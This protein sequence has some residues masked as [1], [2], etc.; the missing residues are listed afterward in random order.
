MR[1]L[2]E[3]PRAFEF[4]IQLSTGTLALNEVQARA[5]VQG[6]REHGIVFYCKDCGAL[7]HPSFVMN[8]DRRKLPNGAP[9]PGTC[10]ECASPG[11]YLLIHTVGHALMVWSRMVKEIREAND[12]I[13]RENRLEAQRLDAEKCAHERRLRQAASELADAMHR[14]SGPRED[15]RAQR[16]RTNGWERIR[17]GAAATAA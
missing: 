6:S 13:S 4:N 1:K 15:R 12:E 5:L 14:H 7:V 11:S 10:R 8:P 2:I 16:A 3:K 17:Q 9:V